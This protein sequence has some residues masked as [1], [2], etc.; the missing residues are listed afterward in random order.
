MTRVLR[1]KVNP[2][3][4]AS[5][6]PWFT[7][8]LPEPY[9]SIYELCEASDQH[10]SL[11]TYR[12]RLFPDQKHT[13]LPPETLHH[14]TLQVTELSQDDI[15]S[16]PNRNNTP[17]ARAKRS[18]L[19][20]IRW[21]GSD[22]PSVGQIWMVVYAFFTV[23][24]ELEAFRMKILILSP[25]ALVLAQQLQAVGL[26]REHPN[27]SAPPGQP[28]PVS[29]DHEDVLVIFRGSFWQGAG[30]PFGVRPLWVVGS[31]NNNPAGSVYPI[32]PLDYTITTKFPEARVYARHPV[33][34]SKP[35]PGSTIYSRY[36]HHLQEI[37][38]M[39]ALD[40]KNEKHLEYFHVWQ[41]DP[42]V[43]QS[44]NEKGTLEQ[45]REYLRK[46]H[47]DQH[48]FAVLGKFN[49]NYFAYFEIYWAK[50]RS[51]GLRGI[52][53]TSKCMN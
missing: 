1:S 35:T 20:E 51:P 38:S 11:T 15:I 26:A 41:N 36:I 30:S 52:C 19:T 21:D 7:I 8:R 44:W 32:R 39:V 43:A 49:D 16:V 29:H 33:R 4:M 6:K 45:H 37:F 31:A 10:S 12:L 28:T 53:I 13:P 40:W 18:P 22:A 9:N 23:Y 46:I 5:L 42:R 3:E 50:V 47:E 25:P 24:P 17:W 48:Q 2:Q 14:D 27:P 34:P